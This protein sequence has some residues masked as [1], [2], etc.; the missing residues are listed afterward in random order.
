MRKIA[1]IGGGQAGLMLGFK[2][3]NAGYPVT[4][5]TDRTP[6]QVLNCR[7]PSTAFL[8]DST[9]NMERELGLNF[10][11]DLAPFGEGIHVDFRTPDGNSV[12]TVQ[13]S[14]GTK[15][16]Q[17]LDQRTKFC[18][19]LQEYEKRG[20]KLIVQ[21]VSV[22]DL[23]T[24]AKEN[25]LTLVA[26]GKGPINAL[27]QR[28][29]SRSVHE[30]A[31][32][33]LAAFVAV[34]KKLTGDRP[35]KRAPFRPLRFN[36]IFG[37]GEFFSLPFY[38]HSR[39]ESRSFLF[40]AVPGGPMDIFQD[41]RSGEELIKL[42]KEVV[43][44]Y[45][46]D[47]LHH[48]DQ[49]ELA[50]A[51]AWLKGSFVPTVRKPI[52]ILPSGA[53][54]MALGDTAVVNDPIAGQGANNAARMVSYVFDR[55]VAQGDKPFDQDWMSDVFETF[56]N[57]S[58]KY[59]TNFTNALLQPPGEPIMAVLQAATTNKAIADDFMQCFDNPRTYWPWIEDLDAARQF[60]AERTPRAVA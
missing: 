1:L 37:V 52:G 42:A 28:D 30:K 15:K 7:I 8:F 27:F 18:R 59:T 23:E 29:D 36:F 57:E 47:D 5:Y 58:A 13:G 14:L 4:I 43:A 56:W 41:A 10:W 45:A 40:E 25:D 39:G 48:M 22:S 55:I 53:K 12:M 17:A 32:R 38:T 49:I 33:N 35:W 3:L 6:E 21:A 20:G 31:P 60:V 50:D 54:V 16:G 9:L 34:G 44:K 19:W 46:P 11:E 24:I 51:D 2:L 26:A